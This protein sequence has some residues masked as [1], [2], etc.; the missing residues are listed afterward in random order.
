MNELLR[1]QGKKNWERPLMGGARPAS[2]LENQ[3]TALEV[4]AASTHA[5]KGGSRSKRKEKRHSLKGGK[6]GEN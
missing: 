4:A 5:Q 2:T 3:K 6:Q 1:G